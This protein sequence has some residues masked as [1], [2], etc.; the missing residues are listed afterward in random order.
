MT[1]FILSI[2]LAQVLGLFDKDYFGGGKYKKFLL[3]TKIVPLKKLSKMT[4]DK[5][6]KV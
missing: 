5:S 3:G 2:V 6:K 4:A 1:G